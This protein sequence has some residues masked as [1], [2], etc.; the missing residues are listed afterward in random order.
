MLIVEPS[1]MTNSVD[2]FDTPALVIAHSMVTG[3]VADELAVENA[4]N[5]ACDMSIRKRY[6][7]FRVTIQ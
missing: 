1:G 4:V 6:G 5:S 3:R 7:F 2:R